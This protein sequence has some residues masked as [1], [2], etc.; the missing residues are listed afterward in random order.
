MRIGARD[1]ARLWIAFEQT[2]IGNWHLTI[3]LTDLHL[4]AGADGHVGSSV[5]ALKY[6]RE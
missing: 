1:R 2:V 3:L 6:Y 5:I 4:R